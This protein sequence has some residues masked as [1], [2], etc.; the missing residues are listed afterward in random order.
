MTSVLVRRELDAAG[1]EGA[2]L[3]SG[4]ARCR[5]LNAEH[6]RTYYVATLLLPPAKRPFVHALYGFARYADEIVDRL[7]PSRSARDRADEFERWSAQ[8][9]ADLEHGTSDDPIC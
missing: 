5:A 1:I 9:S 7:D 2:A 4:Y 8:V 6:G 3:R